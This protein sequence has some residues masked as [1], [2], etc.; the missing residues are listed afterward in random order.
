MTAAAAVRTVDLALGFAGEPVV[1]GLDLDVDAGEILVVVGPPA[2]ASPP[3]CARSPACS[4]ARRRGPRRRRAI[5]GPSPTGRWSSRTTR[6]CR[7]ARRGATSSC[8]WRIRGVAAPSGAPRAAEWLDQVGLAGHEDRLP[9]QLSGGMRQRVQL[10]RTLAGAPGRIF[11][12]EPFGALDAQ[13][14]AAMQ[15]LLVEVWQASGHRRVRHPRRRRGAA[16]RRPGRR[17]RPRT[18]SSPSTASRTRATS[19]AR[20]QP[21]VGRD[22]RRQPRP[23]TEIA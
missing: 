4:A 20:W 9:G 19:P 13:T 1:A 15:R 23:T 21:R 3:C 12:D 5:T 10:A 11:M 18:A 22:P 16:A 17:A 7:G 8:R 2:A 14:R 6:C